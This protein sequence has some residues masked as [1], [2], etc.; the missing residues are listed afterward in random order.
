MKRREAHLIFQV[1]LK[2]L[3]AKGF[4]SIRTISDNIYTKFEQ[5]KTSAETAESSNVLVF[6]NVDLI[7]HSNPYPLVLLV[8]VLAVFILIS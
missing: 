7:L 2:R 8:F 6:C 1:L 5:I 3:L 4:M